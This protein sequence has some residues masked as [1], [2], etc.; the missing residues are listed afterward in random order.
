MAGIASDISHVVPASCGNETLVLPPPIVCKPCNHSFRKVEQAFA[1]EPLFNFQASTLGVVHGRSGKRFAHDRYGLGDFI[2]SHPSPRAIRIEFEETMVGSAALEYAVEVEIAGV[3]KTIALQRLELIPRRL[4]LLS[5]VIY[6]ML[7]EWYAN[8]Y[9]VKGKDIP[10]P[11]DPVFNDVRSYAREGYPQ[12]YVRPYL[13]FLT[14]MTDAMDFYVVRE[15]PPLVFEMDL[16]GTHYCGALTGT[17]AEVLDAIRDRAGTVAVRSVV[18][19][20][21]VEVV[22]PGPHTIAGSWAPT[23]P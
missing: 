23:R 10:A 2:T 16:L 15:P 7:F 14:G 12:N 19:A 21:T 22:D 13:R 6:K 9:Y 5:R 18:V 8:A 20:D 17:R 11:T 3:R 1:D 4:A